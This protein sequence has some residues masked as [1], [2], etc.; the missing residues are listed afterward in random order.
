MVV[1][2][3]ASRVVGELR[4]ESR[5]SDP[6]LLSTDYLPCPSEQLY[7]NGPY[8]HHLWITGQCQN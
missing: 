4:P 5:G 8:T 3:A 7:R 1:R 6:W 2:R